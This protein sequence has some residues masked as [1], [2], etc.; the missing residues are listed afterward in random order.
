MMDASDRH[1]GQ[2]DKATKNKQTD[3]SLCPFLCLLVGVLD[4]I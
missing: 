3:V 4:G 2:E 1:N